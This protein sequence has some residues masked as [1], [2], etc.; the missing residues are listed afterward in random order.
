MSVTKVPMKGTNTAV[1]TADVYDDGGVNS[2]SSSLI[3]NTEYFYKVK[4][5]DDN[6][7]C[8]KSKCSSFMT[9]TQAGCGV[10]Q[11]VTKLD[12]PTGWNV[13]YD[14]ESDGTYEHITVE[15]CVLKA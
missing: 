12:V 9:D 2:L 15:V 11:F 10:C 14:L 6:N 8:G 7:N 13:M 4:V 1:D 5:C 3:N